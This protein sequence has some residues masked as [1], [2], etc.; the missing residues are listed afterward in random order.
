MNLIYKICNSSF[1][2]YFVFHKAAFMNSANIELS[3]L[4]DWCHNSMLYTL[5]G[6]FMF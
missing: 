1:W 6:Y 5:V 4:N 2:S 3:I